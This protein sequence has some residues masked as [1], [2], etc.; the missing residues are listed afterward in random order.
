MYRAASSTVDSIGGS[1]FV[2]AHQDQ[3]EAIVGRRDMSPG[4]GVHDRPRMFEHT[5]AGIRKRERSLERD[6]ARL[7]LY[8]VGK[9]KRSNALAWSHTSNHLFTAFRQ[10]SD[11]GPCR[12][13]THQDLSPPLL[14]ARLYD[15]GQSF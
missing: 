6:Y 9:T 14:P 3:A 7:D 15:P 2:H 10:H 5:H 4:L 8:E 13:D 12:P 1:S 11:R